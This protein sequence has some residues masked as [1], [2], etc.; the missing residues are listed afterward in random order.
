MNRFYIKEKHQLLICSML[1]DHAKC[2]DKNQNQ[3]EFA[4]SEIFAKTNT[5]W[6][7][8]FQILL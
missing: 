6:Q 5:N 7:Q 4:K 3:I 8:G 2:L 1:C